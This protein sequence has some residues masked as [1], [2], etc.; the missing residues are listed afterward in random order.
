MRTTAL[1]ISDLLLSKLSNYIA[2]QM[3]LSF[4]EGR[5][6][7]LE[8]GIGSAASEFGFQE[9]EHCAEWLLS[10]PL[11]RTQFA[12]RPAGSGN[13]TLARR[14][15]R[16]HHPPSVS[17][18]GSP[19]RHAD[20]RGWYPAVCRSQP[21]PHARPGR[22][23]SPVFPRP[24]VSTAHNWQYARSAMVAVRAPDGTP[25]PARGQPRLI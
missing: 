9:I 15:S 24:P 23:A 2:D 7:D 16:S 6:R 3:G 17:G 21:S 11:T 19:P 18:S 10:S 25:W 22:S 12:A 4:P 8:R 14:D 5:W 13:T 20:L 1:K